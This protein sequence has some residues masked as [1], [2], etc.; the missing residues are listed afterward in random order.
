MRM[1]QS[2]RAGAMSLAAAVAAIVTMVTGC[3]AGGSSPASHAAAGARAPGG[4]SASARPAT[5]P[6]SST[7]AS[8]SQP[9]AGLVTAAV[10]ELKAGGSVHVNITSDTDGTTIRF[11]Q[12]STATGGRQDMTFDGV[13]HA[14]VLLISGVGYLQADEA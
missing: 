5:T 13:G 7:P 9:G 14:T 12:D 8:P 10:A 2:P 3:T 4:A 11:S 6:A 1:P